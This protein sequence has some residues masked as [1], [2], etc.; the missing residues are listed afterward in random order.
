MC[1]CV[2]TYWK[3][4]FLSKHLEGSTSFGSIIH[5]AIIIAFIAEVVGTSV[6]SGFPVLGSRG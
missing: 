4:I 6:A 1:V 5:C 2:P 3:A